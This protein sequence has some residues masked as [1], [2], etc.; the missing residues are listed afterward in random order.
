MAGATDAWLIT[1]ITT[2]RV[3]AGHSPLMALPL[4]ESEEWGLS[5]RMGPGHFWV[6]GSER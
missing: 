5:G 2:G 1:I 6:A 3:D 4:A